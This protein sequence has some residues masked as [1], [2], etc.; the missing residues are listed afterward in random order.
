M[1]SS[2]S[3]FQSQEVLHAR[4]ELVLQKKIEKLKAALHYTLD[5]FLMVKSKLF[6]ESIRERS[7]VDL[8]EIAKKNNKYLPS[9][10]QIINEFEAKELKMRK[11]S[12]RR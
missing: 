6:R 2:S 9:V 7:L 5:P 1:R 10:N 11:I 8:R 4:E 3:L 12:S